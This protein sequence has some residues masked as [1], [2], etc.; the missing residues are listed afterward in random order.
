MGIL[1]LVDKLKIEKKGYF[2]SHI[3]ILKIEKRYLFFF[4]MKKSI[5][6]AIF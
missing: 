5:F 3:L 4:G 6:L 1:P 2:L